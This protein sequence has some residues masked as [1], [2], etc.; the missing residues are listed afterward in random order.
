MRKLLLTLV[1]VLV[2]T[3]AS[4]AYDY[5]FINPYEATV[6]GT[7]SYYQ[8]I[9]PQDIPVKQLALRVFEDREIPDVFWHQD[10][11][12]CSL[13]YQKAEAPLI[14]IIAGTGA[15]H[16]SSKMQFMERLFY[17]AG[18]HVIC[19]PSPTVSNFIVS[20]ST[21]MVPGH[22]ENDSRD[23]YR[24]MALAWNQVKSRIKVSG[25]YLTGYS[26][27]ATQSAYVAHLDEAQGLFGFEK[28]LL[29]NP[30]VSLFNSVG[31]LDTM[32]VENIP[33]G[34]DNFNQF[35]EDMIQGFSRIYRTMGHVDFSS[36]YLYEVSKRFPPKESTLAALIGVSFRLSSSN[37]VFTTDVMTRSG[38]VVPVNRRL[39]ANDSLT[40]YFKVTNRISFTDYFNDLYYPFF[41]ARDPGLTREALIAQAGLKPIG[42]YLARSAKIA[43]LTNSDDLI[44]APGELD[45]LAQLFGPRA[46]I[47]P[48]GGHCGNL[49]HEAVSHFMVNFFKN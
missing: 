46:Q 39:S 35:F 48:T 22:L 18:F 27:G 1:G 14:F 2:A 8:V 47:Y 11:L 43:V 19:L 40:E 28:V 9:L 38:L 41:H 31:I 5:P 23:L 26:L 34:P 7:P 6:L 32:L 49:T 37:M 24:V 29:I 42:D 36:D 20:A 15:G 12:R 21:T 16:R 17:Q 30:A 45:Y 4:A 10:R 33:G 3:A 25:F 13:A 44:L